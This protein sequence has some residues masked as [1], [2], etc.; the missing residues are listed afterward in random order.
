MALLT[1][2]TKE[3]GHIQ[4][5]L[6]NYELSDLKYSG[7]ITE[8]INMVNTP[9]TNTTDSAFVN[10]VNVTLSEMDWNFI[11]FNANDAFRLADSLTDKVKAIVIANWN[12]VSI[13]LFVQ[14]LFSILEDEKGQISIY[15]V[16]MLKTG[17]A[18]MKNAMVDKLIDDVLASDTN[19]N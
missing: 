16:K 12:A 13:K 10:W 14:A 17:A 15:K 1:F 2:L 8:L 19:K 6:E 3:V 18:Y 9:S 7:S 4:P 5:T 11:L